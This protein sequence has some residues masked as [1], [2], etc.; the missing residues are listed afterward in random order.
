MPAE[1]VVVSGAGA[2]VDPWHP[3]PVTSALLARAIGELGRTVEVREDVEAVLCAPGGC[4][5]LVVN[6]GNPSEPRSPDVLEAVRGGLR[7]HQ[8]AGGALLGVHSSAT[9]F[10]GLSEWSTIF[11]GRWIRG[12]SMHPPKDRGRIAR[13]AS[14]HPIS[15]KL[16]DFVV[17]DERYS[18]LHT[19]PDVTVLFDHEHDGRR[20]PVVWAKDDGAA[21]V[22]YDALGHDADSYAS[23]GRVALL[24]SEVRWLLGET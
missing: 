15:A 8:D 16:T 5:L 10:T 6:I 22:V 3:F 7:S 19:E 2:Y 21:R 23:E 17:H 11:G 1:V 9:S 13:T 14:V 4:R 18:Y 20:H 12:R 24:R